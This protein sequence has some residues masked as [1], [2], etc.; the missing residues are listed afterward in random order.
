MINQILEFTINPAREVAM[1]SSGYPQTG[2]NLGFRSSND[3]G[4][5]WQKA[6][7]V[8]TH[9]PIDFHTMTVGNNPEIIYTVSG[10]G[11]NI[12]ISTD[13]GKNWTITSPLGGQQVITLAA[14]QSN[15]NNVY[16]ST[17]GGLFSSWAKERIGNKLTMSY[18]LAMIR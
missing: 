6:S 11:D 13:E 2:D 1:Y 4:E 18:S 7:D 16:A 14:N 3:Y 15:S 17:T 9:A 5:T 10:M 12:F 8:T